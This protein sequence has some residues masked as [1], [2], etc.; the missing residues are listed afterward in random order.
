MVKPNKIF[1]VANG[2]HGWQVFQFYDANEAC[3]WVLRAAKYEETRFLC[4][5]YTYK[6]EDEMEKYKVSGVDSIFGYF[7]E[8]FDDKNKAYSFYMYLLENASSVEIVPIKA[9][10]GC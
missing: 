5:E 7:E 1:G 8:V 9:E 2:D 6:G 10:P 4:D 3:C